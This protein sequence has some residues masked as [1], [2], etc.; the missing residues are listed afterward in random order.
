MFLFFCE[1]RSVI[2]NLSCVKFKLLYRLCPQSTTA[3]SRSLDSKTLFNYEFKNWICAHPL[4]DENSPNGS[5]SQYF[6]ACNLDHLSI[7]IWPLIKHCEMV[8]CR[9]SQLMA[10]TPL[11]QSAIWVEDSTLRES[12]LRSTRSTADTAVSESCRGLT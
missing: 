11:P 2:H 1:N 7:G 8:L 12:A 5:S 9:W 4:D 10:S 3:L 6:G